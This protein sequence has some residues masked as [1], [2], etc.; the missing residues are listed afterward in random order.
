MNIKLTNKCKIPYK[1]DQEKLTKKILSNIPAKYLEGIHEIIFHDDSANPV[2]QSQVSD[3]E[4]ELST[5]HI[6]MGGFSKEGK[7]S[8]MHFNILFNGL[9]T[10]HIV[11]HLKPRTQ[12]TDILAIKRSRMNH[13][14]W[15]SFGL[16]TPLIRLLIL[17][18]FFYR[19]SQFM[20]KQVKKGTDMINRDLEKIEKGGGDK[21]IAT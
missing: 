6:F 15:L 21:H 18:G 4:L 8:R 11:H 12:D 3:K 20:Q 16:W 14:E 19:R 9:I 17:V 7:F 2:V 10:D 1:P 13:P 5:F